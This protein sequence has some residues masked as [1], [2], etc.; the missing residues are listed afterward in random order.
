MNLPFTV[1]NPAYV[2]GKIPFG[3]DKKF[4]FKNVEVPFEKVNLLFRD[5]F[6]LSRP[7]IKEV[8]CERTS[9]DLSDIYN[10]DCSYCVLDFD[11]VMTLEDSQSIVEYFKNNNYSVNIFKSRSWG[12]DGYNLKGVMLINTESTKTMTQAHLNYLEAQLSGLCTLDRSSSHVCS[13]QAPAHNGEGLLYN[14]GDRIEESLL[15]DYIPRLPQKF[16]FEFSDDSLKWFWN[17]MLLVHNATP[18]AS[19]NANGT[20]NVSLPSE[21]KSSF[22]YF[23]NY[24]YPWLI[25]HPNKDKT[26]NM[27]F[28][29][30]K[31]DL[32]K[33]FIKEKNLERFR[34]YFSHVDS[35]TKLSQNSRYVEVD[36]NVR[37]ALKLL[38]PNTVLMVKAI[39]GGGKSNVVEEYNKT[40]K[41]TLFITMRRTLS[42]DMLEK[43]DAKHYLE[44]MGEVSN[45]YR[46]GD[47]LIIQVDS[48]YKIN[49]LFFDTIVMDEFESIC[50]YTQA[51]M[52]KS[53]H[54]IKNMKVLYALFNS[55]KKFIIM[56]TFLNNFSVNLYFKDKTKILVENTYKDEAKV[57]SYTNRE[58]FINVLEYRCKTKESNEVVTCSFGTLTELKAT[59]SLIEQHNLK[60]IVLNSDTNDEIKKLMS[61][62]FKEDSVIYDVV[63]YSPTITV[64]IS[65]LNNVKHH[66]H[67]DS[68]KSVDPISSIQMLKRSR[69]ATNIH[70]C[71]GGD[72]ITQKSFDVAILNERTKLRLNQLD[73][74]H[75][76]MVFYN[77]DTNSISELGKFTNKF[78]AH[79]N[80]YSNNHRETCM[81]MLGVQ[82]KTINEIDETTHNSKFTKFLK[83]ERSL[84]GNKDLFLG[85][86]LDYPLD[87]MDYDDALITKDNIKILL[88]EVKR[89]FYCLSDDEV[90][91]IAKEYQLDKGYLDKIKNLYFYTL[92]KE[93]KKKVFQEKVLNNQKS[94]M[95]GGKDYSCMEFLMKAT[96]QDMYTA[97]EVKLLGSLDNYIK[98]G[99]I[100]KNSCLKLSEDIRGVVNK[101][102]SKGHQL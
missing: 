61:N 81:Y 98:C 95:S 1:F 57:F 58:T 16:D 53:M 87:L 99:Y 96:L 75:S 21:K 56:D 68:G 84:K 19:Q 64:G 67:Y 17:N 42:Y 79:S 27:F 55:N 50:L 94:I 92:S 3:F 30:I 83:D 41:R 49:P 93:K 73:I 5:Y 65:I 91:S 32:G 88:L 59:K 47:N 85:F 11:N 39:M 48:I 46:Q 37:E 66:F 36:N 29:F 20:I 74:D 72:K 22:S 40:H 80:F 14:M 25:Q 97:K 62:L 7:L 18:K 52:S 77:S 86:K 24:E 33:T 45:R 43:Y 101:L 2:K 63:L 9:E 31:T 13:Y 76:M 60:V 26:V 8:I 12:I 102:L 35:N 10:T 6:V 51:N 54:Y 23:W 44:H 90:L 69:R 89:E 28:E 82:F 100:K 70:V 4:Q 34:T 38:V 78:I 15:L 71:I